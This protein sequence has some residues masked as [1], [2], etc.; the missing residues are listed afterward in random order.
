MATRKQ[1]AALARGRAIRR[2]NLSKRK[3]TRRNI[4]KSKKRTNFSFKGL[5]KKIEAF[6]KGVKTASDVSGNIFSPLTAVASG[7]EAGARIKNAISS[8]FED[9]RQMDTGK[10]KVILANLK[11]KLLNRNPL[12]INEPIMEK[13]ND[14]N[15][16]LLYIDMLK[17]NGEDDEAK[18]EIRYT[19]R[20]VADIMEVYQKIMN[21]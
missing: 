14:V 15:K 18:R 4:R 1:L 3:T 21:K 9:D 17:D 2:A 20:M 12:N 6:G 8:F 13:I 7:L 10:M 16:S 5:G 19:L 11:K